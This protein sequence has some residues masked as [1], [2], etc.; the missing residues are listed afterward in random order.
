[1]RILVLSDK[2]LSRRLGDGLRVHGLLK[3]L[4][5]KHQFDL[6]CFSRGTEELEPD[7]RS[8]FRSVTLIPAPAQR[9]SPLLRRVFKSISG[10]NFKLT[11]ESM[12]TAV[13]EAIRTRSYD[14]ILEEAANTVPNLPDGPLGA[15]LIV[16]SIDEPLLRE[17]RALRH[18]PWRD[19]PEH[20]YRA[21][22]FWHYERAM[23]TRASVNV[24]VSE[25]DATVYARCFPGRKTA[26]VPNGVDTEYFAPMQVDP[27]SSYLVFE[28]NMNFEPNVD[29]AQVLVKEILPR[30]RRRVANASVGLI[31]RNP[32]EAVRA[33]ASEHVEV[34]GTV[35][36]VRPYLAR[37]TV[38]ACPMRLGS[39]IKNKIL[40]AWAMARPVVAT[41]ESLGGINAQDELN[42]LVR[43]NPD[44][45]AEAVVGLILDPARA[46]QLG[47]EGRKTVEQSYSWNARATQLDLLFQEVVAVGQSRSGVGRTCT[48]K[49]V[50]LI[51]SSAKEQR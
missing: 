15:P 40:Q 8:I 36:D 18:S 28:G 38:F 20:L 50:S 19:R 21:W 42:I 23:L 51:A 14:L 11:S 3:P 48:D 27:D 22:R 1:M 32:T 37:A 16:D 25:V 49:E 43:D 24:Y 46:T 10:G 47:A 44:D 5:Q 31:G 41:S 2:V 45:F 30:V 29:T 17:L 13:E 35:E 9:R 12:R 26:V 39:G 33:L 34:T 7:L 4:A 6:I